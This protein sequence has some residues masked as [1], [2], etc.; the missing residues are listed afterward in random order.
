M[1]LVATCRSCPEQYELR[2]DQGTVF[3]YFRLR[4]GRYSVTVPD[5]GGEVVYEADW[6]DDDP[7]K[8]GF[9]SQPEAVQQLSLGL[10]HVFNAYYLGWVEDRT[11]DWDQLDHVLE[12]MRADQAALWSAGSPAD[13]SPG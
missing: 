10:F 1:K 8:G 3:A 11:L 13:G 4:G 5:V 2:D 12:Q 9:D 7:Y 6:H